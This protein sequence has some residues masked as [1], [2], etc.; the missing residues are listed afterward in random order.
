V[1]MTRETD[2]TL[3]S[4]DRV[5]V[6]NSF[7]ADILVSIH[8]NAGPSSAK[9][10]ETFYSIN[11]PIGDKGHKL[12]N[13]VLQNTV[14]YTG[15]GSRGAK[16]RKSTS[17]PSKDYYFMIRDTKPAAIIIEAAFHTN[18]SEEQLLKTEEFR[19]KVAL[20]IARGIVEYYGFDW[21]EPSL[22]NP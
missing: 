13:L 3:N 15:V 18:P 1:F 20:G 8:T 10:A 5:N 9:G 21:K 16:T 7:G 4:T 11:S 22:I 2:K 17:D 12:A 14:N 6:S 19:Y